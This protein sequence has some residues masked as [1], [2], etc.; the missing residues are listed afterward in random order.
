MTTWCWY[1]VVLWIRNERF[2]ASGTLIC[3]CLLKH[4]KRLTQKERFFVRFSS[5]ITKTS[6]QTN[7]HNS[8]AISPWWNTKPIEHKSLLLLLSTL[9]GDPE[10]RVLVRPYITPTW[11]CTLVPLHSYPLSYWMTPTFIKVNMAQLQCDAL[12]SYSRCLSVLD[13]LKSQFMRLLQ[14]RKKIDFR[15]NLIFCRVRTWF[16]LPV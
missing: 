16:L 15:T 12:I 14:T 8:L 6:Q 2:K 4:K 5:I 10:D 3:H 1:N 11:E 9:N 13:F 7:W